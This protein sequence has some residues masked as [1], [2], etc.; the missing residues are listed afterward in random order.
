MFTQLF[1][2]YLL[3]NNLLTPSQIADAMEA[4]QST[5]V[6]LGVLAINAG[7]LTA[8]QVDK[9]HDLQ[10][11]MD[12]RMGDI[13]VELGYITP[14]KVDELLMSQKSGYLALGQ[15]IVDKGYLTNAELANALAKYKKDAMITD[16]DLATESDDKTEIVLSD[17]YEISSEDAFDGITDYITLLFKNIVRFIGTDFSM[18]K[19]EK[20]ETINCAMTA[21]QMVCGSINLLTAICA[22]EKAFAGIA[23]RYA[24]EELTDSEYIAASVGEF[25]NLHNGLFTVNMSQQKGIELELQPQAVEP[26][27]FAG[28]GGGYIMP[29]AF[30]FG[31]IRFVVASR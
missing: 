7:Y 4:A 29:V 12:K 19:P 2:G 24:G 30:P 21:G 6:K 9:C 11:R 28:A 20:A 17:Y 25:L 5:R 10:S 23:S 31:V 26:R 27:G 1:G 16:R 15:A 3:N 14:A 22:D 18:L 13:A 8:A